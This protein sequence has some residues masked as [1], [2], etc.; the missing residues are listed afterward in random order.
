MRSSTNSRKIRPVQRAASEGSVFQV[1]PVS[2]VSHKRDYFPE[3]SASQNN[4][5]NANNRNF[6][7][8]GVA[9]DRPQCTQS[10]SILFLVEIRA[11]VSRV[12]ASGGTRMV[13]KGARVIDDNVSGLI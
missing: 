10:R 8:T 3:P 4:V 6:S 11:E 9:N 13:A 12:A 1:S 5:N 7:R 2:P